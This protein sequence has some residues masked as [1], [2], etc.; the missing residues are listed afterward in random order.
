MRTWFTSDHH[1]HHHN[2]LNFKDDE[3]ELIRPFSSVDEMHS[4]MIE[5][6]NEIVAPDDK[7]YHLGDVVMRTTAKYFDIL[8]QLNGRKVLIRGNH[9]GAKLSMYAQYFKDIRAVMH[10]KTPDN[11]MVWFSHIPLHPSTVGKGFNVHGHLHQNKIEDRRYINI[12]V[13][14]TD[15]YPV[16]WDLLCNTIKLRKGEIYEQ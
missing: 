12:S 4:V 8:N 6:W 16:S 11:D 2:I 1:F 10:L 5:R 14:N 15:Y 7:V 3:G 9:D 13:E